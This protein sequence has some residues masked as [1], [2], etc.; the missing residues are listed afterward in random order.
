MDFLGKLLGKVEQGAGTIAHNLQGNAQ[1]TLSGIGRLLGGTSDQSQP[2]STPNLADASHVRGT[3]AVQNAADRQGYQPWFRAL[4]QGTNPTVGNISGGMGSGG[5]YQPWLNQIQLKPN[6]LD[7]YTIT[8]EGL[9]AAFARKSPQAQ[10]A[11][12]QVAQQANPIQRNALN[13]PMQLGSALYGGQQ[14]LT[15]VHSFLPQFGQNSPTQ[16]YYNH[17]FTNPVFNGDVQAKYGIA[18]ATGFNTQNP[19]TPLPPQQFG[20]N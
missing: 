3:L 20:D 14:P 9:H 17:Y 16:S 8:H 11:F 4:V 15:E 5:D 7:P 13:S 2:V 1:N 10:Q 6:Q 19:G 12:A 18:N